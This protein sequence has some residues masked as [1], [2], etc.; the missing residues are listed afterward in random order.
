MSRITK[1]IRKLKLTFA[2]SAFL[3]VVGIAAVY[4]WFDVK[5]EDNGYYVVELN[6]EKM[7]TVESVEDAD[8]AVLEARKKLE[9]EK[10]ENLYVDYEFGVYEQNEVIA[11]IDNIDDVTAKI[12]D[13]L[14]ESVVETKVKA[15]T[16][17]I[18]GETITLAS[19]YDV[20]KL[21]NAAKSKFDKEDD[22]SAVLSV[23]NTQRNSMISYDMVS[24][25]T[26]LHKLDTVFASENGIDEKDVDESYF[27][28]PDHIIGIKYKEDIT[29]TEA[30]VS[31]SQITDVDEAIEYV[32]KEKEEN[33]IYVVQNGDSFYLIADEFDLTID[34]LMAM[35]P[36]YTVDSVIR[37]GDRITVT[38]P[39]SELSVIVNEQKTYEE[40]YDLPINYIY[41]DTKYTTYS[42]T[43]EEG[44]PGKRKVV[45]NVT[46]V[47]GVETDREIIIEDVLVEGKSATV[48]VGTVTPPTF[49]KPIS[50]GTMTDPYGMRWGRLHAGQDWAISSGSAVVASC[51]GTVIEAGWAGSYGYCVVISHP[52]GMKTRYA[53]LSSIVVEYGQQVDQGELIAYSGNTGFSTGAHLHFELL[54]YG[55]PVNPLDYIQ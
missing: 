17:S 54:M 48:V 27:E 49:I 16:I 40:V 34:E 21:L 25:Q 46:Y 36:D 4:P 44:V 20:E 28:I 3:V 55:T 2:S 45:A 8:E 1:H 43:I 12:Y 23:D 38:V 7:G 14:S 13:Q 42:E 32:T 50:G 31:Q 30:Y 9:K 19:V 11:K 47:N 18:D 15:Y 26:S 6:G 29:I 37:A 33:E 22:F 53:H 5:N 41:D 24:A 52:D 35:N 10:G 51:G 39:Q